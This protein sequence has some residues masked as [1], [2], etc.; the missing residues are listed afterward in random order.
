MSGWEGLSSTDA[1]WGLLHPPIP[2]GCYRPCRLW[3]QLVKRKLC[4]TCPRE[5]PGIPDYLLWSGFGGY[6]KAKQVFCKSLWCRHRLPQLPLHPG[7]PQPLPT[8][9]P[10]AAAP[11]PGRGLSWHQ[12]LAHREKQSTIRDVAAPLC[13]HWGWELIL[14]LTGEMER[15]CLTKQLHNNSR[16]TMIEITSSLKLLSNPTHE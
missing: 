7:Q 5:L 4:K 8:S 11:W 2:N 6:I 3:Q 9:C 12:S 16:R 14:P 1:P 13:R 15:L 10:G